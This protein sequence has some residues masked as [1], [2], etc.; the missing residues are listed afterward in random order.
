MTL[1]IRIVDAFTATAFKG[2]Q[3][4]V[5]ILETFPADSVMQNIAMEM[6]LAETAFLVRKTPLHYS[7]RWFTPVVEV[8]LCGHATLAATHV[9]LQTGAIAAGDKV[10]FDTLSDVLVASVAKDGTITLDFP[11]LAGKAAT[12]PALS[13]LNTEIVAS[14][15]N[16]DNYL[17]EVKDY[18]TLMNCSPDFKALAALDLQGAIV[19]TAKGVPSGYD[20][21]SRYFAPA[22]G[23]D[24][25][26]VTGS[27]HCFLAPY[28]AAKLNKNS[29]RALQASKRTGT[30]DVAIA[31]DRVML[32]GRAVTTFEGELQITLSAKEKAA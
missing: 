8:N 9:L 23:I 1:A 17:V 29:F 5:C 19:T 13:A 28:W 25:D 3:A 24:E 27:A 12:H 14:E 11:L 10:C 4:G 31:G 32:S 7:L 20:F 22:A 15:K 26:P 6:N 16:R 30:L 2:N 21:A 18:A